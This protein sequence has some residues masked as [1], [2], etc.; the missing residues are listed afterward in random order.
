MQRRVNAEKKSAICETRVKTQNQQE[1]R[2]PYA[3][4]QAAQ[5][6][7][8]R[9]GIGVVNAARTRT[10]CAAAENRTAQKEAAQR[11]GAYTIT[12]AVRRRTEAKRTATGDKPNRTRTKENL[13]ETTSIPEP[14]MSPEGRRRV[15]QGRGVR[16]AE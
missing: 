8:D 2:E 12:A 15:R 3:R 5:R 1:E 16:E 7:Y 13:Q 14:A 11:A 10:A 6:T 4:R 9:G